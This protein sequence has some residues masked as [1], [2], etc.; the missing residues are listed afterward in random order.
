MPAILLVDEHGIY[1]RGIR[2]LIEEQAGLARVT[3]C[4]NLRGAF[5]EVF[6]LLLIDSNCLDQHSH[7]HLLQEARTRAPRMRLAM[8]STSS[9][10][11][12]VLSLRDFMGTCTRHSRRPNGCMRSPICFQDEY[13]CRSG[14]PSR[15]MPKLSRW[16]VWSL[17]ASVCR[18]G[19][20]KFFRCWPKVCPPKK[21]LASLTSL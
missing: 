3:A 17:K 15:A 13:T 9:A 18:A 4:A 12:D 1:R 8:M 6:N 14:F 16:S 7:H 5:D 2:A 19:S 20:G 11:S 10:R 21:L